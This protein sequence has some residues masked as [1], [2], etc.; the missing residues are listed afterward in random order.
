[1][2]ALNGYT[3]PATD[4]ARR[5]ALVLVSRRELKLWAHG[6]HLYD[7]LAIESAA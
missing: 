4:F 2:I 1:M 3:Q 5:H 6:Q 7:V